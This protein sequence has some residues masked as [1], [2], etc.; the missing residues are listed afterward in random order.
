MNLQQDKI[1]YED[2]IDLIDYVKVIIKRK[3]EILTVFVFAV[4]IAFLFSV[5]FPKIYK[6][7]TALEIGK[8]GE[9]TVEVPQQL[10]EKIK[11][12]VFGILVREKLKIS[13]RDF[14]KYFQIKPENPKDTYLVQ[15]E[16]DSKKPQ[17]AQKILEETNNLILSDHQEKIKA[18][19]ELL[20]K[21]IER[22]KNKVSS[23][24]EEKKNL[25]AKIE[26]LQK[27]LLYQQDPGTQFALFDTKEKLERKKQEIENLYLK[28]NSLERTLEDIL[29][30]QI[31]KPP[32]ISE[33]PIR[34]KPL[35]NIVI[36]GVL[37]IFLGVF[38]AFLKEWW[39][40]NKAK[41]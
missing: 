26:A 39:E 35:L 10:V 24:E 2:E 23:L 9:E 6:I 32:T 34:P 4:V 31:A 22:L 8:I 1:E 15:I 3:R 41:I 36:A 27:V 13:E 5:F 25:E 33:V 17:L 11:N 21:D 12:D 19:E 28:I 7:D 37:G 20:K 29:P 38:W 16:I 30:T 40:K 18:K 14:E